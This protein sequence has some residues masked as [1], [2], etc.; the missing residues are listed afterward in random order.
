MSS[1]IPRLGVRQGS[2]HHGDAGGREVDHGADNSS[3]QPGDA[4]GPS[5]CQ[6][7]MNENGVTYRFFEGNGWPKE[8]SVRDRLHL[9][10]HHPNLAST[11]RC[12]QI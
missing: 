1:I 12:L 3:Q 9:G 4:T 2:T 8:N 6:Q 10:R 7:N 11:S 5:G